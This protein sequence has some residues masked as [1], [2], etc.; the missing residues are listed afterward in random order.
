MI[1]HNKEKALQ[2][3]Y[4]QG[5]KFECTGCG[6]CCTGASGF[7]YLSEKDI[8]N[9]IHYLGIDVVKFIEHYTILVKIFGE[10]RLSLKEI[11]N[12]DCIFF[13]DKKCTI[14]P[15]RPY[16]CRSYPFWKKNIES[17]KNWTCVSKE[18]PGVNKG[19]LYTKFQIESIIADVP[20]YNI[21]NFKGLIDVEI[22]KMESNC[23]RFCF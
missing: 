23:I 7:V 3:F 5:L 20:N 13:K 10:K 22:R 19:R 21:N 12:Y 6:S 16:Q 1:M 9:I 14:Y 8:C 17:K 11:S 4:D 15:V 2:K 18:C